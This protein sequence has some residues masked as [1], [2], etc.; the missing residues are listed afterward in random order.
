M[1]EVLAVLNSQ[2]GQLELREKEPGQAFQSRRP[3]QDQTPSSQPHAPVPLQPLASVLMGVRQGLPRT[4]QKIPAH[5]LPV[6]KS[7]PTPHPPPPARPTQ[8][9]RP[10]A[11]AAVPTQGQA[12]SE[13]E[14]RPLSGQPRKTNKSLWGFLHCLWPL[15]VPALQRQTQ[16]V[17]PEV[18]AHS[19]LPISPT[20]AHPA[21]ATNAGRAVAPRGLGG[22]SRRLPPCPHA[23]R[24]VKERADGPSCSRKRTNSLVIVNLPR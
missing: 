10:V 19:T 18:S 13:T 22:G 3:R 8:F 9:P 14:G 5:S 23:S 7:L 21:S 6:P 1:C 17:P 12:Q 2:P 24:G 4:P 11:T 16:P 15:E 20:R